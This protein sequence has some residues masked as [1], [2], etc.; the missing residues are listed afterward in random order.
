MGWEV[1]GRFKRERT[2]A[3]PGLIHADV[4]QKPTQSCKAII[5]QLKTETFTFFKNFTLLEFSILTKLERPLIPAE[6]NKITKRLISGF[7]IYLFFPKKPIC[8]SHKRLFSLHPSTK[9]GTEACSF[10]HLASYTF[11][12]S[13]I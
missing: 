11:V 3:Y 6:T 1:G 9:L 8:S 7:L 2:H 4:W 5:L 12:V 10:N 13:C